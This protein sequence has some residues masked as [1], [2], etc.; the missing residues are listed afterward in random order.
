M[1]RS[2]TRRQALSYGGAGA[3]ALVGGGL[4]PRALKGYG[5]AP[6]RAAGGCATLTPSF[7]EGPYW[8][9][10]DLHRSD[11]T[12]NTA[13]ASSQ[14]SVAQDGVALTLTINVID[15]TNNCAA[16][17]NAYVDIW[18]ANAY[19]LYSDESSQA[20]GGGTTATDTSGQNYLR[21]YQ[22]TGVDA[23]TG[24]VPVDGQVVF[25]TIW[26]G[27]YS[28]R[29]IHIHVRVRTYD[30]TNNVVT[31][32][33]TQILFTDADNSHV[34]QSAAPYNTRSTV[35]SPTTDADDTVVPASSDSTQVVSVAGSIANGYAATFEI[36]IDE[37]TVSTGATG[38]G[39]G[40]AGSTTTS[41]TSTSSAP[42]SGSSD[43]GVLRA[44]LR[45]VRCRR[46]V[47]GSRRLLATVTANEKVTVNAQIVRQGRRIAGTHAHLTKGTHP[48][49]ITIPKAVHA[50]D[51]TLVVHL[52]DTL[53][54]T[55]ALRHA[56]HIPT[57]I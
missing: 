26:P 44:S 53:G 6:A 10:L 34:L 45:G 37:G 31:N 49:R 19:G 29:V 39:S 3:V 28:G 46:G 5:V 18:H 47:H 22:I 43:A 16:Y 13:D 36:T 21:G 40:G 35:D 30:A 57:R 15:A 56:I 23:A 55:K 48:M 50:G 41:S 54:H 2:I 24:G 4:L 51:A 38:P 1:T 8:V 17:N 32:Y 14:P 33:T 12:A 52:A 7:T 11:V 20:A 25:Q 9:D 42:S 27:W